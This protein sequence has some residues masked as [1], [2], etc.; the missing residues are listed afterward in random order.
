MKKFDLEK[1]LLQFFV[2]FQ[3]IKGLLCK[4][5]ANFLQ[6]S[7]KWC[8]DPWVEL[9]NGKFYLVGSLPTSYFLASKYCSRKGGV[10]AEISS[11]NDYLLILRELGSQAS[12]SVWVSD[13]F[14]PEYFSQKWRD[15]YGPGEPNHSGKCLYLSRSNRYL[16]RDTSCSRLKLP[17]CQFSEA[18][19]PCQNG[20]DTISKSSK[21]KTITG[22]DCHLPFTYNGETFHKCTK[23]FDLD[24]KPWCSTNTDKFGVHDGQKNWGYCDPSCTK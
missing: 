14:R 20:E 19:H 8:D 11:E 6:G 3:T 2:V 17:L 15:F 7:S 1:L 13:H 9:L 10:L 5:T 12:G 21:C 23:K 22:K 18:K 16:W 4:T 24:E